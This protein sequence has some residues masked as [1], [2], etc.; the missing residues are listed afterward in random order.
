MPCRF[1]IVFSS[2][3]LVSVVC[4]CESVPVLSICMSIYAAKQKVEQLSFGPSN[5][6]GR[7]HR[8]TVFNADMFITE[9]YLQPFNLNLRG[10]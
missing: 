4:F 9:I 2:P 5:R 1:L 8:P 7:K 10:C 3:C 6:H